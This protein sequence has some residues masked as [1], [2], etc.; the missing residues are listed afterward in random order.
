MMET[1]FKRGY[2]SEGEASG[3]WRWFEL[4]SGPTLSAYESEAA[5]SA[6]APATY[7]LPLTGAAVLSSQHSLLLELFVADQM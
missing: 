2:L 3:T 7:S 1:V 5:A 4:T 6:G